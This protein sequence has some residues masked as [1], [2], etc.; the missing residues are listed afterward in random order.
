MPHEGPRAAYRWYVLLV[1]FL[2]YVVNFVDRQIVSSL[3]GPIRAE[4]G[5]SDLQMGLLGGPAFALLY[6]IAGIPIARL[7]D[8]GN[9]RNVVAA[10]LAAWS[11][12]TALCGAASSYGMLLLL[13]VGVGIGEAGGSAPSHALIADYF[14]PRER[15]RALALLAT[16]I[17]VGIF[18]GLVTGSQFAADWRNAFVIAGLP[19][20][21]L[22]LLVR[23][24]IREPARDANAPAAKAGP[25]VVDSLRA[26]VRLP[27][28]PR[29]LVAAS[30]AAFSGYAF[31]FWGYEFFARLHDLDR[32]AIGWQ[33][34]LIT[35]VGGGLGTA[36][37]GQLGD[38]YGR[39]DLRGYAS[40]C[41]WGLLATVPLGAA[42]LYATG[43][44][45][46][47]AF[48]AAF[49]FAGAVYAGPMYAILQGVA[50][51]HLRTMAAALL[52]LCTNIVG[53]G[54]GPAFVGWLSPVI[55]PGAGDDA[56]Q[57]S[58]AVVT[59]LNVPAALLFLSVGRQ[60]ASAQR[61]EPIAR[62]SSDA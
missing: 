38:R 11:A 36:I 61:A 59:A 41:A 26:L 15:G 7:A 3:V 39:S 22:A 35:A 29:L 13:R 55:A 9:R 62:S 44:T 25:S 47:F 32:P 2:V 52:F 27:G 5:A 42:T 40:V 45:E 56:I 57:H 17:H 14:P 51:P 50:P 60:L 21:A 37:G 12:F 10:A 53:L 54:I 30:I 18:I 33:L 31:A 24:T 16:G 19:G 4:L 23:F 28:I 8:T 43:A 20:I 48:G 58:L 1:L 49:L 6:S 34:G 46:A